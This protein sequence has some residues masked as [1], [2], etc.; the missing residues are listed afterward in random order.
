MKVTPLDIQQ[1]RFHIAFRGYDR[2]EVDEF[3]DLIREEMEALVREV[4]ELREFHQAYEERLRSIAEREDA[5]K[6]T[7]LTTQKL[8]DDLKE[9]ARKE[10]ALIVKEA[11]V[12]SQQIGA[13]A[14]QER[15]KLDA[16]IQ[17]LKRRRHHF[18]EDMKKVIQMHLE[19]VKYEETG[20]DTKEEPRAE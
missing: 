7:M 9:N 5:L 6:S 10:A 15:A 4:T 19:M 1:K 2:R 17:N 13:A 12:R 3:L 8:V 20:G 11:E 14:Q 18:L 16:D